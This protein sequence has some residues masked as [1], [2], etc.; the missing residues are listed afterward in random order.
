M[1]LK[2][3]SLEHAHNKGEHGRLLWMACLVTKSRMDTGNYE[4]RVF[5]TKTL[6]YTKGGHYQKAYILLEIPF[7]ASRMCYK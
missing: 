1:R 2:N 6:A 7:G 5:L 3:C 4:E